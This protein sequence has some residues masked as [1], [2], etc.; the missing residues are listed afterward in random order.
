MNQEALHLLVQVPILGVF[1]WFVIHYQKAFHTYLHARNTKLEK[2]MGE[3]A[4]SL[5]EVSVQLGKNREILARVHERVDYHVH[6]KK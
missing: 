5:K 3:V 1:V 4:T 6:E 2:A